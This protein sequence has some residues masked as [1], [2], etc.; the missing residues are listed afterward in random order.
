MNIKNNLKTS[1]PGQTDKTVNSRSIAKT[2]NRR[3][4]VKTNQDYN[5]IVNLT[6]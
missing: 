2:Q 1:G 3:F 6:L 5:N 4:N